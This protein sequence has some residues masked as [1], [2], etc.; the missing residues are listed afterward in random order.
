MNTV[1]VTEN[2]MTHNVKL[3]LHCE[4][5]QVRSSNPAGQNMPSEDTLFN[6]HLIIWRL[7]SEP[8]L[9]NYR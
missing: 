3:R 5:L 7:L 1:T 6:F 4:E 2:G 8:G 9:N